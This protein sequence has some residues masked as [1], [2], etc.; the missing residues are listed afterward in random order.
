MKRR[1]ACI[2]LIL[3]SLLCGKGMAL[4]RAS[5]GAERVQAQE[6][7]SVVKHLTA[8]AR[9]DRPWSAPDLRNFSDALREKRPSEL[10]SQEEYE[11]AEL[12]DIAERTNPETKV[13]WA[14]AK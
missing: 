4:L 11:L 7:S 3:V 9:P 10:E 12:I 5:Q 1:P 8:P 13:A 6:E 14:R 2:A